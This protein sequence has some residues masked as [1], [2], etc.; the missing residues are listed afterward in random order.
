MSTSCL[1]TLKYSEWLILTTICISI[2][3]YT[4]KDTEPTYYIR[5]VFLLFPSPQCIGENFLWLQQYRWD[6]PTSLL[7]VTCILLHM[8]I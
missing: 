1:E 3:N 7:D 8:D 6:V 2:N 4:G 5:Q